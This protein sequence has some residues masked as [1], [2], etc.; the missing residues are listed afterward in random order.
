MT[1]TH[2]H[3]EPCEAG[4]CPATTTIPIVFEFG[5]DPVEMGFIASLSRPGGN[6]IGITNLSVDL[7]PKKLEPLHKTVS[8]LAPLSWRGEVLGSGYLV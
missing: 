2:F 7:G 5:V 1:I 8:G 6:I 4:A 3:D